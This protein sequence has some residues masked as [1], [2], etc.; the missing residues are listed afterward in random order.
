MSAPSKIHTI[1]LV[2]IQPEERLAAASELHPPPC[3]AADCCDAREVGHRTATQVKVLE[4]KIYFVS[5]VDVFHLAESSTPIT[6][7]PNLRSWDPAGSAEI[8]LG[9]TS[10]GGGAGLEDTMRTWGAENVHLIGIYRVKPVNGEVSQMAL[11]G[12][13]QLTVSFA[14]LATLALPT[15]LLCLR[16][17][18]P[19]KQ[20]NACGGK[21]LVG[22][23][24]R[25]GP[26]FHTQMRV[27]GSNKT[28]PI[29]QLTDD[30]DVSSE[31]SDGGKLHVWFCE[32]AH[33]NPLTNTLAGCA[34]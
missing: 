25:Q 6:I 24:L 12:S 32:A 17:V 15:A 9:D 20:S 14:M 29:T 33:S 30:G 16:F 4:S 3:L 19:L 5:E 8:W 2:K 1:Q 34:L 7:S 23:A 10:H 13:D 18:L 22:K 21:G 26:I 31:G 27:R 11:W 28:G